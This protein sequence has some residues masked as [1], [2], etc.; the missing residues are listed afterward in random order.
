[1]RV[2]GCGCADRRLQRSQK[3]C[4][5]LT[6]TISPSLSLTL[7]LARARLTHTLQQLGI[8]MKGKACRIAPTEADQSAATLRSGGLVGFTPNSLPAAA[9]APPPQPATATSTAAAAAA[10]AAAA[11]CSIPAVS[12]GLRW[13][14]AKDRLAPSCLAPSSF[15]ADGT[16]SSAATTG[17]LAAAR[18]WS[19]AGCRTGGKVEPDWFALSQDSYKASTFERRDA[20]VERQ[21]DA[22]IEELGVA[23]LGIKVKPNARMRM[24]DLQALLLHMNTQGII[25][26]QRT[27]DLCGNCML[28]FAEI[29]V[30]RVME[31]NAGVRR[32]VAED[33]SGCWLVNG[34]SV[35]KQP[36]GSV[37][38]VLRQIGV[39][40]ERGTRGPA[41]TD[42]GKR[43]F[44]YYH[45]FRYDRVLMARNKNRLETGWIGM[46]HSEMTDQKETRVK[47][48]ATGGGE[49]EDDGGDVGNGNETHG[50][51]GVPGDH[52]KNPERGGEGEK[53]TGV[54]A[55]SG[56]AATGFELADVIGSGGEEGKKEEGHG[57]NLEGEKMQ[58]E[59]RK[60]QVSSVAMQGA[61]GEAGHKTATACLPTVAETTVIAAAATADTAPKASVQAP[62]VTTREGDFESRSNLDRAPMA[63]PASTGADGA[64]DSVEAASTPQ[65]ALASVPA[66]APAPVQLDSVGAPGAARPGV[67]ERQAGVSG[68]GGGECGG[69]GRGE[70]T[71]QCTQS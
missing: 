38:E 35:L 40:P 55:D 47:T 31:F 37:Y 71:K 14:E 56:A 11:E 50:D 2:C 27:E 70:A 22:I 32:M 26:L 17:C 52:D 1:M 63:P 44:M 33:I 3:Q 62:P 36:T 54:K 28:G 19:T 6:L 20:V 64:L 66:P 60:S 65:P 61:H 23:M 30:H 9:A 51:T 53:D 5:A 18:S 8:A 49:D 67:E 25:T 43:D 69:G 12:P 46:A 57:G 21:E 29:H 58:E 39:K 10:A 7:S 16:T 4:S 42:P 34:K 24:R 48:T 15:V 13:Q 59:A 45:K 41:E 68:G